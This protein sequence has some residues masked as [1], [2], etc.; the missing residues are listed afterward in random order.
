MVL[1][2]GTV[3]VTACSSAGSS[4]AAKGGGLG[5]T[6]VLAGLSSQEAMIEA[7]AVKPFEKLHPGLTVQ[8][9]E[10]QTAQNLSR[11]EAEK[12]SPSIDV[13]ETAATQQYQGAQAGLFATLS[14]MQIPGLSSV[15]LVSRLDN[16]GV[17]MWTALGGIEY[18]AKVFKAKGWA[19]PTSWSDL[20]DSR[21]KGHVGIYD[22]S[23]AIPQGLLQYAAEQS[24]GS[25]TNVTPGLDEFAKHLKP[26]LY[27]VLPTAAALTTAIQQ[28][29]VWLAPNT[30]Q[31]VGADQQAGLP[32]AFAQPA[33]GVLAVAN[34]FD[35]VKG[36]PH[37]AAGTALIQYMTTAAVQKCLPA[38]GVTPADSSVS[39]ASKY[40]ALTK[41]TSKIIDT[42]WN[43]LTSQLSSIL[44]EWNSKV[45]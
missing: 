24:G 26:N 33:N 3:L 41:P 39:I 19:P 34:Y 1:V 6:V 4:G 2:A 42:N 11:V 10:N 16:Y 20:Y 9:I 18:N 43:A 21:Y 8:Y 45:G 30:S 31:L 37:S 14:S 44:A 28:G 17:P 32:V 5:S 7:C 23:I 12:S 35:L 22:I 13:L 40:A 27:A 36:A 29:N 25:A 15:T 38:Y